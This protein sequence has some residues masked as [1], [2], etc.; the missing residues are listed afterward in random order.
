MKY[1]IYPLLLV[2]L[3]HF[4]SLAL[5]GT[6]C[7]SSWKLSKLEFSPSDPYLKT[8]LGFSYGSEVTKYI[9]K[10][11]GAISRFY[12]EGKE[13]NSKFT[14]FSTYYATE[15][16]AKDAFNHLKKRVKGKDLQDASLKAN[17]VIWFAGLGISKECFKTLKDIES[18]KL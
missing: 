14:F 1:I 4:D 3:G 2:L 13:E 9:P 5:A 12:Y 16:D 10:L 8:V 15:E 11:S 6:A 17:Q 18:A 7:N